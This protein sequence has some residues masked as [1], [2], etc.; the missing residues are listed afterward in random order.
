MLLMSFHMQLFREHR[1]LYI[2]VML[3]AGKQCS[4]E[5]YH[6]LRVNVVRSITQDN[7]H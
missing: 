1:P 6:G 3:V 2:S 5:V 7:I 4:F